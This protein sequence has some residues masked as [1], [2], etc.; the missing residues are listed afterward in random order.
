M[1]DATV[2]AVPQLLRTDAR[3][4]SRQHAAELQALQRL[5]AGWQHCSAVCRYERLPD[6]DA[7]LRR[8]AQLLHES[9]ELTALLR[10]TAAQLERADSGRFHGSRPAHARQPALHSRSSG[11]ADDLT[12]LV[13]ALLR[14]PQAGPA[15]PVEMQQL[16]SVSSTWAWRIS[17]AQ[18]SGG[19]L[20]TEYG[21]DF[22]LPPAAVVLFGGGSITGALISITLLST[23]SDA[24]RTDAAL[25]VQLEQQLWHSIFANVDQQAARRIAVQLEQHYRQLCRDLAVRAPQRPADEPPATPDSI[26]PPELRHTLDEQH[27]VVSPAALQAGA[28]SPISSY[29]GEELRLLRLNEQEYLVAVNGLNLQTMQAAPNGIVSVLDTA[30][31][32][33]ALAQNAYYHHI[34]ATLIAQ[35]DQLPPG[36]QLHLCGHSMGGGIVMLLSH[37]PI[38]SSALADHQLQLA[39]LVTI[40]AVRPAG[41]WGLPAAG[42]PGPTVH[43]VDFDDR[44]AREVGAGHEAGQPGVVLFER[45]AAESAVTAHTSYSDLAAQL[46]P[47][48]QAWLP[49]V[50]DLSLLAVLPIVA[51]PQVRRRRRRT[52]QPR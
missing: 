15:R 5:N 44:L 19:L 1:N 43:Y 18:L 20:I 37:D 8:S 14:G 33:T 47:A 30:A 16:A 42:L 41:D 52:E 2:G 21:T 48:E 22:G 3:Q 7:L 13:F 49:W 40:G 12:Q 45:G 9:D 51:P 17:L 25:P 24:A 32:E 34:R 11:R 6:A 31:G 39:S 35:L 38:V 29:L 10:H 23:A 50:V 36:S 28:Q 46:L 27:F 4:I 26:F